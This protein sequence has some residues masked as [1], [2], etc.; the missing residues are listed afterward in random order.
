MTEKDVLLK[1]ANA[2]EGLGY[3]RYVRHAR[4][5]DV[6]RGNAD[7]PESVCL[8]GAL[9]I[10]LGE[11]TLNMDHPIIQLIGTAIARAPVNKSAFLYCTQ[12]SNATDGQTVVRGLRALANSL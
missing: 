9:E 11:E 1:A 4:Q 6:D 12:W 10:A 7:R 3:A 5:Q 2:M 8:L